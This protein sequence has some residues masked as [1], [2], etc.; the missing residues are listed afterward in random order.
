MRQLFQSRPEFVWY[1]SNIIKTNS[2]NKRLI[3]IQF[4]YQLCTQTKQ[5]ASV[6]DSD[7]T[8]GTLLALHLST[9]ALAY[10]PF[11]GLKLSL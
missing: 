8:K 4:F 1:I 5:T 6:T 11:L 9:A 2:V 3:L 7:I 10:L